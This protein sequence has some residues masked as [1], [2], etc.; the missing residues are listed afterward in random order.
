M[1]FEKNG[2]D[3]SGFDARGYNRWG[4]DKNGR[5]PYNMTSNEVDTQI[6]Q[7]Q[8]EW[9]ENFQKDTALEQYFGGLEWGCDQGINVL[10]DVT[11]PTGRAT[12]CIYNF[13]KNEGAGFGEAAADRDNTEDHIASGAIN[14]GVDAGMRYLWDDSVSKW[15]TNLN[16]RS[17]T[18][19]L[20]RSMTYSLQPAV[21]VSGFVVNT[22]VRSSVS[23]ALKNYMPKSPRNQLIKDP[24]KNWFNEQH[25]GKTEGKVGE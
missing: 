14:G 20:Y 3:K 1:S 5:C 19:L 24:V 25:A 10:S 6:Q 2:F 11:G 12:T 21:K 16:G 22:A 9:L 17:I 4:F 18:G 15:T 23:G 7:R 8:Q 13:F